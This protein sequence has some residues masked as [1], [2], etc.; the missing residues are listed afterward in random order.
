M[1]DFSNI[2]KSTNTLSLHCSFIKM[3]IFQKSISNFFCKNCSL[4]PYAHPTMHEY[5]PLCN[6]YYNSVCMQAYIFDNGHIS[7]S[8]FSLQYKRKCTGNPNQPR[9]VHPHMY[10]NETTQLF[11]TK[12]LIQDSDILCPY[13]SINK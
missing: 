13:S 11:N 10:F 2:F 9:C 8:T 6:T 5:A 1:H 4:I 3:F 12:I 7:N